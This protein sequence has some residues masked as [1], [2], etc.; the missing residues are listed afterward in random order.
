VRVGSAPD[1]KAKLEAQR[2]IAQKCAERIVKVVARQR[3]EEEVTELEPQPE[4]PPLQ[5]LALP[6]P[7][8]RDLPRIV[9]G[10]TLEQ[11]YN[12]AARLMAFDTLQTLAESGERAAVARA[13]A[14]SREN[15][16]VERALSLS[17]QTGAEEANLAQALSRSSQS[18]A[19]EAD[20]A[21]ALSLSSQ[22]STEEVDLAQA[23]SLSVS[24]SRSSISSSVERAEDAKSLSTASTA[25][26]N[27][28][29][30]VARAYAALATKPTCAIARF[31]ALQRVYNI[32]GAVKQRTEDALLA[33]T[34]ELMIMGF[35]RA[36][37]LQAL[38]TTG[39]DR[40]S[41]ADLLI[42]TPQTLTPPSPFVAVADCPCPGVPIS[43]TTSS[44]FDEA[45]VGKLMSLG[46][47]QTAVLQALA[48]SE[49]D[50]RLA[51]N[52]LLG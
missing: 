34:G 45:D 42:S 30:D 24:M 14:K 15:A 31:V 18:G 5:Q 49:G 21:Q 28:D 41:A 40:K 44:G 8:P 36:A 7:R 1:S 52:L 35:G 32:V 33:N 12:F 43:D 46:F 27:E 19:E 11:N 47:E 48:T 10:E 22:N 37:V 25:T 20:L 6:P 29:A 51:A 9:S 23:L 16:D 26:R 17:S 13:L 38:E 3:Q 4:H 39:G 50:R 2:H